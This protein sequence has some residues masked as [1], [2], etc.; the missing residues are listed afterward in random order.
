MH[1]ENA[2]GTFAAH[3]GN[4]LLDA[5]RRHLVGATK[6]ATSISHVDA[7]LCGKGFF[8]NFVTKFSQLAY[9]INWDNPFGGLILAG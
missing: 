4:E 1:K 2:H 7:S 3:E 6:V 9:N 8:P 5:I